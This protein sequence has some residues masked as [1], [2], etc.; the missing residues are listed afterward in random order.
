MLRPPHVR[1]RDT[2]DLTRTWSAL[3][4]RLRFADLTLW[5]LRIDATGRPGPLLTVRGLPDSPYGVRGEDLDD[6]TGEIAGSDAALLYGRPGG[7]PWH[8]GD[9][10][11]VRFL[12]DRGCWPLHLAHDRALA[13]C[14]RAVV[15]GAAQSVHG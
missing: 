15:A 3:R 4:G 10:A 9:R 7:G 12:G 8:R 2:A 5:V 6:L 14:P 1:V 11:W 13:V